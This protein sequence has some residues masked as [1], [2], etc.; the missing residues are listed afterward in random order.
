MTRSL[1]GKAWFF[2]AGLIILIAVA[3][4]VV[5]VLLPY[6]DRYHEE[7]EQW[8]GG[9][10]GQ[11]VSIGSIDVRWHGLG[12]RLTM[13]DVQVLNGSTERPLVKVGQAE[14]AV[15]LL[16]SAL[17]GAP[18]IERLIVSDVHLSVVRARDGTVKFAG[19]EMTPEH[20]A[21]RGARAGGRLLAWMLSQ[22][23]VALSGADITWTDLGSEGGGQLQF[24]DVNLDMRNAGRRHQLE[25]SALL[26]ELFGRRF[27]FAIDL[28]GDAL[29]AGEW[30]ARAYVSGGG[31]RL[32]EWAA[33]ARI[34]GLSLAQGTAEA[35]VWGR[36][37]QGR[38][39][40][41][42]GQVSAFD[43]AVTGRDAGGQATQFT[44]DALSGKF[45]WRRS[46][47]GWRADI[48]N[49]V[50]ARQGRVWPAS[51]IG[52]MVDGEGGE[53]GLTANISYLDLADAAVILSASDLPSV[54]ARDLISRLE[55]QGVIK[56]ARM[57]A[58]LG[59]GRWSYLLRAVFEDV[60]TA[61]YERVPGLAGFD[62]ALHVDHDGGLVEL[63]TRSAELA[64]TTLFRGAIPV[65]TMSGEVRWHRAS[66]GGVT[67]GIKSLLAENQDLKLT[68][69]GELDL[70]AG[71]AGPSIDLTA[72]F[73]AKTAD[74]V[75]R[76]LP[77]GVMP[78]KAV[79]WLDRSIVAGVVPRGHLELRGPLGAFPFD[80]QEGK[81]KVDFA[82]RDG[83]LDY[84]PNWPRIAR[85]DGEV[86]FEGRAMTIRAESGR[87]LS[88]RI[89]GAE[90]RIDDLVGKPAVL[91]IEGK[92]RGRTAD[93]LYYLRETPLAD[94]FGGYAQGMTARGES[95][96]DLRLAIPLDGAP[97]DIDGE[98]DFHDSVLLLAD[99]EID[100]AGIHGR[101]DFTEKGLSAHGMRADILG[102]PATVAVRSEEDNG[103]V[104]TRIEAEGEAAAAELADMLDLWVLDH[105][106]GGA[107]WQAGLRIP[108]TSRMHGPTADLWIAS[109]LKGMA[110]MLPP[111]LAKT[112]A[113][114]RPL[115]LETVLPRSLD[116]PAYLSIGESLRAVLDFDR[117]I[118]L[119]RGEVRFGGAAPRLPE[120]PGLRIAGSMEAASYEE[121]TS[122]TPAADAGRTAVVTELDLDIEDLDFHDHHIQQADI[123]A[124]REA[125][126]WIADIKSKQITGRIEVPH[127]DDMPWR[128]DLNELHLAK[129][130]G[131][132]SEP[133]D[134]RE[135]PAIRIDSEKF[136]YNDIDFGSLSLRASKRPAG[137]HMEKI[138]ASTPS[139]RINASG[140]WVFT[141]R[142]QYSS[143]EIEF[144]TDDFGSALS[145]FGY[146]DTFRQGEG[147]FDIIARWEGPPT[148]FA[149]ERL[150]GSMHLVITDGRLLDV[151]PGPGRIF[152][153]ISLQALP[154]RLTLD[155]SDI[156]KK[157]FTF[158]RIEGNF[159]VS[160]GVAE[161]RD[162]SM[163]GPAAKMEA[164]GRVHLA[165]GTYDQTVVVTPNV[166]SGLPVAGAV[167][168]G[169]GVG[170]AILL[171][172]KLFKPDIERLTRVTY[173]VTGKW[174]DPVIERLQATENSGTETV[175]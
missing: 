86:V 60:A 23:R 51:D 137:L 136:T 123:S 36:W 47:G 79:R 22:R 104:V 70:P 1:L 65:D 114:S 113:Q 67:I 146:A 103:R 115:R 122:L 169:V 97:I 85:I 17:D 135:L 128:L 156:F 144:D 15:N 56:D 111:P 62:G 81:F 87:S 25:G 20:K 163:D 120:G 159:L 41:L 133:L 121:W 153:L 167:A 148:N 26:P 98:L 131:R 76:Y 82:V 125:D 129:M 71:P 116:R 161:T 142:A 164:R 19:I 43:L 74:N 88:S 155:F 44:A 127:A 126:A 105:L 106:S 42:D 46:E 3:L 94:K 93:A 18:H 40:N 75:S 84:A 152:G 8:V 37:V 63:D 54:R 59:P 143:F 95:A 117:G 29:T 83:V 78:P 102:L 175:K 33:G 72:D 96:L 66:A 107:K 168:G 21:E 173:S 12:P 112:R 5:R 10:L 55:P 9:A 172:E 61:A 6:A 50:L 64:F 35:T 157:G 170:A 141:T 165:D 162:L 158:D 151:D 11:Q 134:P 38:M 154:R 68:A 27:S 139:A 160:E 99:G 24:S 132:D 32:A 110:V 48:N 171:M 118:A 150:D 28:Y 119:E 147:H 13:R 80:R 30:D 7:V 14:I 140:D 31:L 69:G 34:G 90:V 2:F 73:S 52:V 16:A 57:H 49:L 77:A 149:L 124:R 91:E 89:T 145:R 109:D 138:Q 39:Q 92:A 100:I 108:G 4:S 45:A 101:L 174:S 58:E 130:Q 53:R 166:S